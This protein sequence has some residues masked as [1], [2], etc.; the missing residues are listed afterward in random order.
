MTAR[1]LQFTGAGDG[2][3]FDSAANWKDLAT[4]TAAT[5]T[6]PVT[7]DS[8]YIDN[9][10]WTINAGLSK[11]AIDLVSLFVG[12]GFTG[13]LGTTGNA[14]TIGVTGQFTYMGRASVCNVA[15]GTNGIAAA[16]V[17]G[18]SS[19]TLSGGTTTALNVQPSGNVYVTAA[20]VVT[21]LVNVGGVT[22]DTGTGFTTVANDGG[23]LVSARNLGTMTASGGTVQGTGTATLTAGMVLASARLNWQSIGTMAACTVGSGGAADAIGSVLPFAITA[24]VIHAGAIRAFDHEVAAITIGSKI[25]NRLYSNA[26]VSI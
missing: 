15:A 19:V 6:T 25:D 20:G 1:A 2:V 12:G 22:A 18:S 13:T 10:S 26:L 8:C 9:G 21:N 7:G 14:L 24:L 5:G 23:T 17:G 3:T 4:G 11:A 16:N